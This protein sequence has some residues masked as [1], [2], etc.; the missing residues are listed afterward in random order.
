MRLNL[1][2]ILLFAC[3]SLPATTYYVSPTGNDANTGTTDG[4]TGAFK[5]IQK[6]ADVMVAGDICRIHAGTYRETVIPS[7]SGVSGS[8]IVYE[9]FGD[10]DVII[11]GTDPV[12]GWTLYSGSIYKATMNWDLGAMNQVFVGVAMGQLARWPNFADVNNPF[13]L[14]NFAYPDAGSALNKIVDNELPV[15]PDNYWK[16]AIL[17]AEFGLKWSSFGTRITSSSGKILNF[18]GGDDNHRAGRT[19]LLSTDKDLY[20]LAGKLDFLDATNEWYYDAAS[21]SLYI[22]VAEGG[23]PGNTVKAKK[24]QFAFDLTN[25]SNITIK[26]IKIVASTIRAK[27]ASYCTIDGV[28]ASYITHTS[29]DGVAPYNGR[30]SF[31]TG[32]DGIYISGSNNTVQNCV[33]RYSAG[34]GVVIGAGDNH[35]VDN[36]DIQY[37]NYIGNYCEG[38]ARSAL[39]TGATGTNIRITRNKVWYAG[40]P[41][42][43]CGLGQEKAINDDYTF[44]AYNDCAYGELI[45]DDRGGING[46]GAEVCYNWVHNIG[47]GLAKGTCPGLYTDLS[48]DF[49]TFHHNVLWNNHDEF[50]IR[51]N[52]TAG[53]GNGNDGIYLFNNTGYNNN[54]APISRKDVTIVDKNNYINATADNFVNV[55][56]GDFRL[57]SSS[58]AISQKI[59][60]YE[61]GGADAVSNWKAG[62]NSTMYYTGDM[63]AVTEVTIKPY[64]ELVL[65]V[66]ETSPRIWTEFTPF[67]PSD[68]TVTWASSNAAIAV[69]NVSSTGSVTITGKGVGICDVTI[70][71]QSGNKTA[72]IKVSVYRS[73]VALNKLATASSS[74]STTWSPGK[75]VDGDKSIIAANRWVS[76]NGAALPQW[77]E[78]NLGAEYFVGGIKFYAG[79]TVNGNN[80]GFSAFKFQV[81]DGTAWKD[82]ITETGNTN[83]RYQKSFSEEKTS[84][85]C[86]YIT[87]VAAE[88]GNLIRLHELEV[89]GGNN[90]ITGIDEIEAPEKPS[91][92]KIYPNPLS[93]GHLSIQINGYTAENLQVTIFD[94]TGRKIFQTLAATANLNNEILRIERGVFSK[95][96]YL[97]KV[98]DGKTNGQV[99]KLIVE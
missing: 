15:K 17:W 11:D 64:P 31:G 50:T 95:G 58:T 94:I 1:L 19:D 39:F 98:G 72:S 59:G 81:W 67:E 13:N 55:A 54:N 23:N 99:S 57:S 29:M 12:T 90:Q 27:D 61:F 89:L 83:A 97:V 35:V 93:S 49:T 56:N 69:V 65:T 62:L 78:V 14:N 26:G 48:G 18:T 30:Q 37:V 91:E 33:I 20:F 42:I 47:A 71:T 66:N 21:Q 3:L 80:P 51:I 82:V 76:G 34:S 4:A 84:K 77:I 44:V 74:Y 68:K 28:T 36:N 5:T 40:G 22:Q 70:T 24:R 79:A 86:L 53:D 41:L 43:T 63:G 60:A 2:I 16:D 10:G 38:I 6:T 96:I 85:V 7:N 46:A 87:S 52:N 8:P 45:G 9:P 92:T 73:N 88:A 32:G 75:A 25:A